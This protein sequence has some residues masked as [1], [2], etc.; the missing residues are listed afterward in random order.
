MLTMI[1]GCL[2]IAPRDTEQKLLD[3][4]AGDGNKNKTN[5]ELKKNITTKSAP[6]RRLKDF[7]ERALKDD[8][9]DYT[10]A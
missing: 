5:D 3:G 10:I 9:S 2:G 1:L 6:V 7:A 8:Y 4:Q